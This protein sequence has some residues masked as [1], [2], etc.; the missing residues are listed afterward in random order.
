MKEEFID[1]EVGGTPLHIATMTRQGQ[2]AAIVFL[3][4]FGSTKEDFA[5]IGRF[6]QFDD[7][8]VIAFDAPGCGV[9]EC[10][11][12]SAI[13]IPFLRA[14]AERVIVHYG[15]SKFH[16]VGHSMGGLTAL[17]LAHHKPSTVL[18]FTNIEGNLDPEDCFLSRQIIEHAEQIPEQFMAAF[19]ARIK[20]APGYSCA[21][22]ASSLPHKVRAS[23]VEPIFRSMVELSDR[24]DLLDT[25]VELRCPKLFMY[26]DEN[27]SLSYLGLLQ[28][29][30][31]QSAQIPCCGHF[32]MYANPLAMWTHIGDFIDRADIDQ[33][34][35]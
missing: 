17:L 9:S 2:R 14:A 1:L 3:H 19:V 7:R 29:H 28:D 35:G 22:Y 16:L 20:R 10:A 31:V 33:P 27:R 34:K 30:G 11:N 8:P 32:P 4:G 24:G 26:G 18:S 15:V 21:L 13:S 12:L 5:D 25:F 6:P 23:A